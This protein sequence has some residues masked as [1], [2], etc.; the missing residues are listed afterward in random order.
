VSGPGAVL[1]VVAV[2]FLIVWAL[3]TLS[4]A[5]AAYDERRMKEDAADEAAHR[6]EVRAALAATNPEPGTKESKP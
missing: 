4:V 6:E 2:V 3:L 5:V 1:G